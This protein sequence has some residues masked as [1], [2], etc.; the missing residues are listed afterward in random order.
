[1][2]CAANGKRKTSDFSTRNP[3]NPASP[4]GAIGGVSKH[5]T[6]VISGNPECQESID[7]PCQISDKHGVEESFKTFFN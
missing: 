1:M 5:L 6:L 2:T 4:R 3:T 7:Q